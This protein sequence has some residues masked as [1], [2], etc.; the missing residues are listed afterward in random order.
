MKNLIELTFILFFAGMLGAC[1]KEE[2]E[3]DTKARVI[4]EW[5]WFGYIP[6]CCDTTTP[7][8]SGMT[9]TLKINETT[10]SEYIN[11]TLQF[12]SSYQ[13]KTASS[14]HDSWEYFLLGSGQRYIIYGVSDTRLVF[15]NSFM[16]HDIY[17]RK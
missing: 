3:S 5:E 15:T 12:S 9:K 17:E 8:S 7:I 4:G 16:D 14:S 10:F 2:N 6:F 1:N 13:I 11:D